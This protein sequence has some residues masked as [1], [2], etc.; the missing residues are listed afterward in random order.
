MENSTLVMLFGVP[1]S[2]LFR[3]LKIA[4][5]ALAEMLVGYGPARIAWSSP[6]QQVKL[7]RLVET[8]DPLLKHTFGFID[9]KKSPCKATVERR[10]PKRHV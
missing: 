9:G 10:S 6:A 3:A 5:K 4:E 2:N 7:A 8:R 1:P